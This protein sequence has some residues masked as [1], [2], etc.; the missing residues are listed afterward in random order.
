MND[1]VIAD[2]LFTAPVGSGNSYFCYEIHGKP[3]TFFNLV[4]DN[5]TSVNAEYI[6]MNGS[7]RGNV[8]GKIGIK[9]TD[10]A[11]N[12]HNIEI[13]LSQSDSSSE[14]LNAYIDGVEVSSVAR[15]NSVYIRRYSNRVRVSVPN[16]ELIDLVMWVTVM[17]LGE[18]NTIKFV[19]TR[20]VNL[21]P[22]SHGLIGKNH[23]LS[24]IKTF[25]DA[26]H[27]TLKEGKLS[28]RP[29]DLPI[30]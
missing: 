8:I 14:L 27:K 28:L 1:T 3:H 21:T 18:Q 22:T 24:R 7:Q 19:I 9:S 29:T 15:V 16:C 2:P 6:P 20:G 13:G 25:S 17:K 11:G 12:C 23:S 4:S 5:C 30:V 10:S 26:W